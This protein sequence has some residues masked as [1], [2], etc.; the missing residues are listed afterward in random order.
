MWSVMLLCTISQGENHTIIEFTP[1]VIIIKHGNGNV[2]SFCLSENRCCWFRRLKRCSVSMLVIRHD[3]E[4]LIGSGELLRTYSPYNFVKYHCNKTTKH[5]LTDE[6]FTRNPPSI[7]HVK[8][9]IMQ[10]LERRVLVTDQN[11]RLR[12]LQG[13]K[14]LLIHSCRAQKNANRSSKVELK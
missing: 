2:E 4:L 14:G 12:P 7:S 11:A 13:L 10:E 8:R 3:P 5:N 6:E 1:C 9:V